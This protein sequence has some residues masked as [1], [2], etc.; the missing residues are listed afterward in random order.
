MKKK[1][2][3]ELAIDRKYELQIHRKKFPRRISK[4]ER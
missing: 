1:N 4:E 2:I 3:S